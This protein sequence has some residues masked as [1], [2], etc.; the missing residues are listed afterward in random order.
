[1]KKSII[2][3]TLICFM[4]N[5]QAQ[6]QPEKDIKSMTNPELKKYYNHKG[7]N[8][9]IGGWFLLGAGAV[10]DAIS[11]ISVSQNLYN[12]EG[13][14]IGV[15]FGTACM[16]GSIPAFILGSKNKNKAAIIVQQTK[17]HILPG[18]KRNVTLNSV[19]IG[20]PIGK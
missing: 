6:V 15:I 2:A 7:K 9:I 18:N 8:Q 11:L 12:A 1:M 13:A 20:I 19:G 3:L 4:N 17:I 16:L 10:I 5:I 14:S